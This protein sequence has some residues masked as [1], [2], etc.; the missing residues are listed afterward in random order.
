MAR[1]LA[2]ALDVDVS[3]IAVRATMTTDRLLKSAA[4]VRAASSAGDVTTRRTDTVVF[5]PVV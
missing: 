2:D 4:E 3:Q 5:C 1:R